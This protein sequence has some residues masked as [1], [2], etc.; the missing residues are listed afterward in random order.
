MRALLGKTKPACDAAAD[1]DYGFWL[2]NSFH[3]NN[4]KN[5]PCKFGLDP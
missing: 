4:D 5:Y 3:L 2:D 1:F